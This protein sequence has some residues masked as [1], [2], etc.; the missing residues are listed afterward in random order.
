MNY[1]HILDLYGDEFNLSP[2]HNFP[3]VQNITV[4]SGEGAEVVG[5]PIPGLTEA[6]VMFMD[7]QR[8]KEIRLGPKWPFAPMEEGECLAL[9][10]VELFVKQ[11]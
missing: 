3:K 7:T 8:E 5:D 1:T 10:T 11:N 4:G 2:R 9:S 6:S